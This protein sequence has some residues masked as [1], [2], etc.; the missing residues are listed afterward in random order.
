M[1]V[2]GESQPP[3]VASTA[4]THPGTSIP[5]LHHLVHWIPTSV[6]VSQ[7]VLGT[8][9]LVFPALDANQED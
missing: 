3:P 6:T 2:P 8:V 9:A 1:A 7:E 4:V 5:V